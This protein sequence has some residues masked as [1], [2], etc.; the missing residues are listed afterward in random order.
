MKKTPIQIELTFDEHKELSARARGQRIA[1]RDAV[2]AKIVLLIAGGR[3]LVSVAREV[4]KQRK[5]VRKWA[6][7]FQQKRLAG[8]VDKSGRGRAP[9]FS[10][11]S[12][13]ALG[14]ARVRAA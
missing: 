11:C 4:G 14:E 8:L 13:D 3:T 1:H 9:D 12:R 10:P 5:V 6:S 7:R 2:R